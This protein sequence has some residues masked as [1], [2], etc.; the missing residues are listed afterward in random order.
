MSGLKPPSPPS[1]RA[2]PLNSA[3]K[4]FCSFW[5]KIG[6]RRSFPV[7]ASLFIQ[8]NFAALEK[9]FSTRPNNSRTHENVFVPDR[10][11]GHGAGNLGLCIRA[12]RSHRAKTGEYVSPERGAGKQRFCS[13]LPSRASG[14]SPETRPPAPALYPQIPRGDKDFC[15]ATFAGPELLG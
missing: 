9:V 1:R 13:N 2:S 7:H 4:G 6:W 15:L 12:A 3:R 11:Q 14:G 8:R 5:P 10:Q